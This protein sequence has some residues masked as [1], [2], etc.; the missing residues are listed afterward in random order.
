MAAYAGARPQTIWYG[1]PLL[2]LRD[3]EMLSY[4]YIVQM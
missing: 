2:L 4:E 3:S 1:T